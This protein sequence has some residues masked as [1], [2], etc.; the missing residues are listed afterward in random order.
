MREY[1]QLYQRMIQV[2]KWNILNQL[3]LTFHFDNEYYFQYFKI[4]IFYLHE[5][6]NEIKKIKQTINLN[7]H[8]TCNTK[9][10]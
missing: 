10:H 7:I 1:L 9:V 5:I 6:E 2:A 4:Y 8:N 3:L